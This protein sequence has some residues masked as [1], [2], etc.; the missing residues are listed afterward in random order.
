MIRKLAMVGLEAA[1]NIG[2]FICDAKSDIDDLPSQTRSAKYPE[3]DCVASGSTAVVVEDAS[4]YILDN[5]GNWKLYRDGSGGG[6]GDV[7]IATDQE[8]ID[9]LYG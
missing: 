5:Q 2:R 1:N 7:D 6:G 4:E 9:F 8:V 3:M